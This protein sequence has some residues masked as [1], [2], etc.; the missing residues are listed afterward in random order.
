[1]VQD[2][3]ELEQR[4]DR[5]E[6]LSP[7]EVATLVGL[8]RTTVHDLLESGR[9]AYTKTPGGHRRVQ[10]EGVRELLAERRRIHGADPEPR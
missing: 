5:G 8:G 10:P 6:E 9:L 1:M 2:R 3:A 7:G 4:L